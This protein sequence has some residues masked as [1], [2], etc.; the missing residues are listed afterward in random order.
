MQAWVFLPGITGQETTYRCGPTDE[1]FHWVGLVVGCLVWSVA[2][3]ILTF[4]PFK[5]P[6]NNYREEMILYVFV[7]V[8]RCLQ[9]SLICLIPPASR[10]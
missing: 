7:C 10:A 2:L 3:Q 8:C 9:W 6:C 4:R 1:C 5:T